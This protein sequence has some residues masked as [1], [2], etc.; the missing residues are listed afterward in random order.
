[1]DDPNQLRIRSRARV[2]ARNRANAQGLARGQPASNLT[3]VLDAGTFCDVTESE[4]LL[5]HNLM[6]KGLSEN[7]VERVAND[8][9]GNQIGRQGLH[10]S[11][12]RTVVWVKCD[13]ARCLRIEPHGSFHQ[14]LPSLALRQHIPEHARHGRVHG[15]GGRQPRCGLDHL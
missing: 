4:T 9:K 1:M 2:V 10:V 7:V 5:G 6:S 8:V 15:V 12:N 11:S 14:S 13:G 3:H